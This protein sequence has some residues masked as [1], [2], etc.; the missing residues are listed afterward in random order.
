[1]LLV[2][3]VTALIC[4][5]TDGLVPFVPVPMMAKMPGGDALCQG[6]TV[7]PTEPQ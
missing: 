5:A 6:V 3:S 4:T 1:M 2:P 7:G